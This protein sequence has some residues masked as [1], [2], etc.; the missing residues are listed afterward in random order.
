MIRVFTGCFVV[1]FAMSQSVLAKNND[2]FSVHSSQKKAL[3]YAKQE[4]QLGNSTNITAQHQVKKRYI[5]YLKNYRQWSVAFKQAQSLEKLGYTHVEVVKNHYERN[6]S[7]T[8]V[9]TLSKEKAGK[10]LNRLRSIGL[11]N[12][13]V[14]NDTIK[15]TRYIVAVHKPKVST[16]LVTPVIQDKTAPIVKLKSPAK[17]SVKNAD[18]KATVK[19][20]PEIKAEDDDTIVIVDED[21]DSAD[22]II[23]GDITDSGDIDKLLAMSDTSNDDFDLEMDDDVESSD[24]DWAVDKIVLE[25][26]LFTRSASDVSNVEY[27]HVSSHINWRMSANWDMQLA[28]RMDAYH[29]HGKHNTDADDV[30]FDYEDTYLRY[31]DDN[32]RLTLGSQ[33]IRWGRVDLLAPTDN[34]V[35]MDLSRGVLP[36]WDDLYRA[37]LAMRGELFLGDS[38]LDLVYLPS[39]REAELPKDKESVWH[40]VNFRTGRMLGGEVNPLSTAIN[41]N[42]TI[43]DHVGG[44][45]GI[46]LRFSSNYSS[47][48]Y[49]LTVQRVRLSAPYYKINQQFG[50]DLLVNPLQALNNQNSYGAT[51]TEEHPRNWIVGGDMAFQWSQVTLRFEGAWFSDMPATT[52]SLEYK[53]YDGAK[54]ATGIEFYPGDADTRVILQLSGNHIDEK[55]KIADRDNAISLSGES[56]TLFSNDRWRFRTKFSLGLDIKDV[57]LSPE[58]SYLGWEPFEVYS[59]IHYLEGSEQSLGGFYQENSM[60]TLG[61]RGRY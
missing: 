6:Y 40:P 22:T 10:T 19:Q 61:W 42:A 57:Y 50:Q 30:S 26:E 41:Q 25:E 21:S 60:F 13:K 47:L 53:T 15:L 29:Q 1:A 11:R 5:V 4:E 35:T 36:D 44:E 39:F 23:M 16:A 32:M 3:E 51:Y 59:A 17:K 49:A 20:S 2:R 45:G 58:L 34:M 24:I 31:R 33:T 48:D 52:K 7:I 28:A 9:Q 46:G 56:E 12:A 27:A 14:K 18:K 37:S 43:E 8:V 38:K 54:W 55:E